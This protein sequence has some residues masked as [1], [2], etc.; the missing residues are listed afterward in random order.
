[1]ANL[2][3]VLAI[4]WLGGLA[5]PALMDEPAT[6]ADIQ[7]TPIVAESST[8]ASAVSDEAV[9]L[10]AERAVAPAVPGQTAGD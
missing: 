3:R 4:A 8:D 9:Q 7:S 10:D 2:W 1:M 5:S 6:V